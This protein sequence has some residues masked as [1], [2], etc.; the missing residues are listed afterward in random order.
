M[1]I[2]TTF[3][4]KLMQYPEKEIIIS[5]DRKYTF[6]DIELMSNYFA[7]KLLIVTKSEII[8]FYLIRTEYVL[9]VVLGI[10]KAG[11]IPLPISNS[12]EITKSLERVK[13]IDFD[14]IIYDGYVD[15]G[16]KV[17]ILDIPQYNEYRKHEQIRKIAEN[18]ISYIICTSGTTGIPK[19]VFLT[20][21]NICWLLQEFYKI[22]DFNSESRFLFTTPY[23]FDVSLTEI[24]C[25]VFTGGTLI[26]YETGVAS[27]LGMK[28]L[29]V[30]NDISHLSL[31]PSFAETIVDTNGP[32]VFES[33]S[34]LCLAGEIFPGT[35]AN[36]L[37]SVI[38]KG[39]R[40]FNL[41]GPSETTIYA[42]YYELENRDYQVVPI[43]KPLPGVNLKFGLKI[44]LEEDEQVE[45]HIGGKGVSSGYLLQPELNSEKFVIFGGDRYYKT[46]DYVYFRDGELI[47][48]SRIDNQ[49]QVNGIRIELDE[50]KSLVDKLEDVYSSQ[51]AFHQKK[52]YI[53]YISKTDIN[54]KIQD[55]LPK[56]VNPITV[57]VDEYYFNQNRKL[58]IIKL[59]DKYY[60]QKKSVARDSVE[61]CILDLLSKFK[62]TDIVDL[63]SLDLVRFFLELEEIF[64]IEIKDTDFHK[65]KSVNSIYNY[66]NNNEVDDIYKEYMGL[67][68]EDNK[69]LQKYLHIDSV[70]EDGF[71]LSPTPTQLRLYQN[72]QFR[73]IYFDLKLKTS[74]LS[75]MGKIEQ[76]IE[77]ISNKIDIFRLVIKKTDNSIEFMISDDI[78]LPKIVWLKT[79]PS[80]E[81]LQQILNSIDIVKI[82]IIVV[83][84]HHKIMRL[85]FP[86]HSIDSSSLNKLEK[87]TFQKFY[88][89]MIDFKR[90]SLIE[91][92]KYKDKMVWNNV[93]SDELEIL[94]KKSSLIE[95]SI[96][97][98]DV[99]IFKLSI[100]NYN[101]KEDKY[102]YTVYSICKC[103]LS[104]YQIKN[105]FGA[106]SFDFREFDNFDATNLIGDVHKKIPFEVNY[107]QRYLDFKSKFEYT[108]SLYSKGI[109]FNE[110]ALRRNDSLGELVK[111]R[112]GYLAISINYL[113]EVLNISSTTRD[114]VEKGFEKNFVNIFSHK[115][116]S[117]FV[118]CSNLLKKMNYSLM[119]NED[120]ITVEEIFDIYE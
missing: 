65:L 37:R 21:E 30:D 81:E 19:K 90:S 78:S 87:I 51:I 94:P 101:S 93:S 79:L 112:L 43:G 70:I 44:E 24:L 71:K 96:L 74:F 3:N 27:I 113:G 20:S 107:S 22:V 28:K 41:Y 60:F 72:R 88:H 63:D 4:E 40:V 91:Y 35:L 66:I 76:I 85:Y 106:L 33:L 17:N 84:T 57:K 49:V 52:V 97:K 1:S 48:G 118:V 15:T 46:G 92:E 59:L 32:D 116:D 9:P 14:T 6:R 73:I 10:M 18:N 36:K 34:A 56:Y 82:P 64:N 105:I 95:L 98:R 11:K 12:L 104:D 26:C 99:R 83:S 103:M 47:F 16:M 62:V 42:T 7:N 29:L 39:C 100:D 114:I 13:D 53:F 108:L 5:Q 86:Y 89:G 54:N 77:E 67:D 45:L 120:K 110:I 50:I 102:L 109:D 68:T 75:E 119:S 31:S 117:Y 58:D 61:Q 55:C 111:K 80:S 23:T 8:P 38:D 69:K 25:P 115:G 2:L